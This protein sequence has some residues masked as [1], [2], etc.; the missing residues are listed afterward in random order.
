MQMPTKYLF[1]SFE[2]AHWFAAAR[3]IQD[4]Q[5]LNTTSFVP[6]YLVK[7]IKALIN[8]LRIWAA[9]KEVGVQLIQSYCSVSTF[10]P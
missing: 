8:S 1:P 10:V 2:A 5:S 7:G 6:A 3:L 4:I 9:E